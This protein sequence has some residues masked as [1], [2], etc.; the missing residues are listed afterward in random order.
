MR[1]EAGV[2]ARC[3]NSESCWSQQSMGN[4]GNLLRATVLTRMFMPV[5]QLAPSV[6]YQL[7]MHRCRTDNLLL[8]IVLAHMCRPVR[9]LVAA[10]RLG[11]S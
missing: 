10:A 5:W 6:D 2:L 7:W 9:Q 1:T 4:T 3:N 8:V 11:C